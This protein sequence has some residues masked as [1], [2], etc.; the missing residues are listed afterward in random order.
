MMPPPT[1]YLLGHSQVGKARGFDPRMRWFESICPSH[2]KIRMYYSYLN[3]FLNCFCK[4]IYI[5]VDSFP[6]F[7]SAFI[8]E[9][10][11]VG[12]SIWLISSQSWVQ[13]LSFLPKPSFTRLPQQHEVRC[14]KST[15]V[16]SSSN[17][18]TRQAVKTQVCQPGLGLVRGVVRYAYHKLT[19]FRCLSQLTFY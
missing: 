12:Q 2:Q 4:I 14:Y 5:T 17:L 16:I 8:Q 9:C 18:P 19:E 15:T 11:S 6:L 3:A 1:A 7:L 13:I 10:N